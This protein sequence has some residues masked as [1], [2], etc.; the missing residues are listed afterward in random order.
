LDRYR[1]QSDSHTKSPVSTP[2]SHDQSFRKV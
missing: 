2:L 1:S